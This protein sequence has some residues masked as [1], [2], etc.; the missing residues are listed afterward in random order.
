MIRGMTGFGTSV[1][2]SGKFKG[3]FEIKSVN[4][5][6]LDIVYYL[7]VG[8]SSYEDGIRQVLSKALDRGRVTVVFKLTDKP[9]Q[10][11]AFNRDVVKEY[12]KHANELA[13]EFK[14][15]EHLGLTDLVRLPGVFEVKE[16][17]LDPVEFGPA[18]ERGLKK[19]IDGMM[20]MRTREGAMLTKDLKDVLKRMLLQLKKIEARTKAILQQKKKELSDDEFLSLQKGNNVA[21]EVAR[22]THHIEEFKSHLKEKVPVGKKLDFVAQEMQRETN[23]IG[24][25][26][27]DKEVS[28]AVI[29]LKSKIEKLREQAQNIE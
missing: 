9:Q 4:H 6:Y 23:T 14:L 7:P 10:E 13:K 8:F 20:R 11:L 28:N 26:V 1:V 15:K 19:A 22:L 24:S 18:F 12:L 2:S 21:E 3:L 29:A 5:R 27:Q 16:T 25:K 17:R